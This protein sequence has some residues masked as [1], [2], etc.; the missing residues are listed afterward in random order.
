M[1]L[2]TGVV[3]LILV[4]L[5]FWY[6]SASLSSMGQEN[7]VTAPVHWVTHSLGLSEASPSVS[8]RITVRWGAST[9]SAEIGLSVGLPVFGAPVQTGA[10]GSSS[11]GSDGAPAASEGAAGGTPSPGSDLLADPVVRLTVPSDQASTNGCIAPCTIVLQSGDC[12]QRC[13][14]TFTVELTGA[15]TGSLADRSVSFDLSGGVSAQLQDQL[16]PGTAVE[17]DVPEGGGPP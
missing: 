6:V 8:G 2:W 17:L 14:T 9:T 16:P 15:S 4:V 3:L 10:S 1:I 12:T 5:G 7:P 11:P 13:S